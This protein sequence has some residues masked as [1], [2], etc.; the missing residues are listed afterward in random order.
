MRIANYNTVADIV[1]R[2]IVEIGKLG[3]YENRKRELSLQPDPDAEQIML[4]DRNSRNACE[5]R[6]LLR[7]ELDRVLEE[8]ARTGNYET[9][10]CGRTFSPPKKTVG[11]VIQEAAESGWKHSMVEALKET[12]GE[13]V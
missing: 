5:M 12:F 3:A 2:L 1:D 4:L 9:I 11:E 8:I 13:E 7:R 6:D 10:S